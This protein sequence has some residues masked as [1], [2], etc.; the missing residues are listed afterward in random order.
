MTKIKGTRIHQS[1]DELT[2]V[3]GAEFQLTDGK[4]L[5]IKDLEIIQD[6]EKMNG[7][8]GLKFQASGNQSARLQGIHIKQPGVEIKISDDPNVRVEINKRTSN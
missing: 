5:H 2:N 6:A 8:T 4:D 7:V 1:A 3:T